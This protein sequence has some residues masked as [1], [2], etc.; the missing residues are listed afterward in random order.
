M[1]HFLSIRELDREIGRCEKRRKEVSRQAEI[2]R[3][4]ADEYFAVWSASLPQIVDTELRARSEARMIDSRTRFDGILE[5]GRRAAAA[6]QPFLAKLRDQWTYLG[7]DLNPSGIASLRPDAL[8]LIESGTQVVVEI[9][10]SLDK[11]FKPGL[12]RQVEAFLAGDARLL[13]PL[14]EQLAMLPVYE[15]MRGA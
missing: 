1:K 4:Q 15:R 8:E 6:Y 11:Q 7:H 3:E 9:D 10:D 13:P 2:T 14:A 5:A 12:Y